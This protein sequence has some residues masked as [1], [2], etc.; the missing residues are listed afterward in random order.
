MHLRLLP[1]VAVSLLLNPALADPAIEPLVGFE[2]GPATPG[3]AP[4]HLHPN[5]SFY[6]TSSTGGAFGYFNSPNTRVGYGTVYQVTPQGEVRGLS[7]GGALGSALG[8]LPGDT[9]NPAI[10]PSADG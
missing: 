8:G 1:A 6:A 7:F 4:L 10:V 9:P 3:G 5:G 2:M